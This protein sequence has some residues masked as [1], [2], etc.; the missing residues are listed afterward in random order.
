M[1]L[2]FL[3]TGSAFSKTNFQ[4]NMLIVQNNKN[5]VVD[6]GT[7]LKFSMKMQGLKPTDIDAIYLSHAHADHIGGVE[8][9]AL[10]TYWTQHK[11]K[12][13]IHESWVDEL[14]DESLKGGLKGIEGKRMH[15]DDYFEVI[16]LKDNED[17]YW[18]GIKFNCIQTLHIFAQYSQIDSFGL[19]FN[20]EGGDRI[21]FTTDC[22]FAPETSQKAFYK[23]ADIIIHDCETAPFMSGV[24][25]HYDQLVTLSP[26]V[27]AKMIL[28]HY[29]ENVDENFLEWVDKALGDGFMG[30]ATRDSIYNERY[31]FQLL[32]SKPKELFS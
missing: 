17:W 4:T 1:E 20:T 8:Y 7:D 13:F 21:Y 32:N 31:G 16:R 24:H 27:K 15:L 3:G 11:I 28:I 9:L 2:K 6:C 25:A 10:A 26:E 29:H 14:W 5:M 22:Q 30:F 19:M 12:L 23:E 18:E